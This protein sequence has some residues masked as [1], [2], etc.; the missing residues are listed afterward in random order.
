MVRPD[1]EAD[2]ADG[3]HRVG[4]AEIA[5]DRLAREGRDDLA[6]DAE[7]RQDEDVDFGMAEEPEQVLEQDRIAAAGIEEACV[8]KL[9]SVSSMVMAPPSTGSDSSSRKAVT[10]TDQTNSGMRCSVMPGRAC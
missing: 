3:D 8:P 6:D 9:R 7:A 5:E 10:S 1:H 4:H 2:D